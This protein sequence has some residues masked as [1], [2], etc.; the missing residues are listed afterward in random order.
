MFSVFTITQT[1]YNVNDKSCGDYGVCQELW[2]APL[3]TDYINFKADNEKV[4]RNIFYKQYSHYS[5]LPD[6][7]YQSAFDNSFN[8]TGG[9]D[10][11]PS[12]CSPTDSR[13]N[14][15]SFCSVL[16]QIANVKMNGLPLSNGSAT[17]K[18]S[19]VYALSFNTTVD[20]EQQP[21][22]HIVIDWG[23][24]SG[25]QSVTGEDHRPDIDTPHAFYHYY[26]K[27]DAPYTIKIKVVDNWDRW[28]CYLDACP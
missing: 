13:V 16:P 15:N 17:I 18:S 28:R 9:S 4:L 8:W 14:P 7:G 10:P 23:D 11:Y 24:N 5:Y 6:A 1:I 21:L 20:K 22:D 26:I 27:R 25:L 2:T 19:G 12:L 3:Q